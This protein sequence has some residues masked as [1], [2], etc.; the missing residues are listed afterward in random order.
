MKRLPRLRPPALARW[1]ALLLLL[2]LPHG[3]LLSAPIPAQPFREGEKLTLSLYWEFIPAG[4]AEFTVLPNTTVNGV[5]ARHF[6]MTARTNTFAD[7]F[8]MVR[9][10][11]DG[12]T[13][14]AL[15][16]SL[17]YVKSQH[18]GSTNHEVKVEFDWKKSEAR[19]F[20]DGRLARTTPIP[21]GSFDPLSVFYRFRTFELAVGKSVEIPLT[22]GAKSIIGKASVLKTE[23]VDAA[24]KKIKAFLLAPEMKHIG[25]VFKESPNAKL[26]VW[27]SADDKKAMVRV[28]GGVVV[29]NFTARLETARNV[30]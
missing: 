5:P 26:F 28:K 18:E 27:C 14:L 30:W 12:Y 23:T 13:D 15:S 16:R 2:A 11:V 3:R 20:E 17:L 9:D 4:V 10:R 6:M 21:A 7:A 8:Y 22:D 24:G 29:G 25:G 1:A 19:F